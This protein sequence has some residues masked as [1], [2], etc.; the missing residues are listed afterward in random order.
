[1]PDDPNGE[2]VLRAYYETRANLHFEV[3]D[4]RGRSVPVDYV[5]IYE[6]VDPRDTF[7]VVARL[8]VPATTREPGSRPRRSRPAT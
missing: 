6:P 2:V 4:D 8:A 1:M 5:H 3:S 7:E